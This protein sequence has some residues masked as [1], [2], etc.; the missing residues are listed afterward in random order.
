M[1]SEHEFNQAGE[2]AFDEAASAAQDAANTADR[3][4]Q[5]ATEKLSEMF[6]MTQMQMPEAFRAMTERSLASARENYARLKA[7]AEESTDVMEDTV[8]NAREGLLQVQFKALD[9]AKA[10]TDAAFDHARQMLGVTSFADAIQLQSAFMRSRFEALMDQGNGMRDLLT[11][12]TEDTSRPARTAA[13]KN[14]DK[15]T[16]H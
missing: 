14:L 3:A 7:A 13:K 12:V 15:V 6:G 9:N 4:F 1:S 8:E 11:K 2:K 5:D 16:S 10:N